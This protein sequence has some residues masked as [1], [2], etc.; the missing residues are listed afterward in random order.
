MVSWEHRFV[1][2]RRWTAGARIGSSRR[3]DYAESMVRLRELSRRS[4][5]F[6]RKIN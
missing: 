1:V 3:D 6:P 4:L 5:V 2:D